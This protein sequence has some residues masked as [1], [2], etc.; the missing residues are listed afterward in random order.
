M[1]IRYDKT[2][3]Q[4]TSYKIYSIASRDIHV[5]QTLFQDGG[6]GRMK[7][8]L[9]LKWKFSLKKTSEEFLQKGIARVG[10]GRDKNAPG[11]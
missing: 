11:N 10:N 4:N 3:N 9:N 2:A 5:G 8:K 6:R 1:I 7:A